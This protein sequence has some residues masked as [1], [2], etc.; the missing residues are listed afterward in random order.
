MDEEASLQL[1]LIVGA[2]RSGTTLLRLLLDAHREI[3]CPAEA[4][5]PG[6]MSHMLRVWGTIDADIR[7][8]AC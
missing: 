5:L 4:G 7:D 6:L 3:G 2:A 8:E 1:G